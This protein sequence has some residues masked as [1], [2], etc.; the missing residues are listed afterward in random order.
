MSRA[1]F[2]GQNRS[3][4]TPHPCR[5]EPGSEI[6]GHPFLPLRWEI[7]HTH[8]HTRTHT[9]AHT[10][11]RTHT[12]THAHTHTHTHT[13]THAHTHTRTHTHT[14]AHTHTHVREEC[15][16]TSDRKKETTSCQCCNISHPWWIYK[17][18]LHWNQN[19]T[20]MMEN[21][22]LYVYTIR[23]YR[24][25]FTWLMG[26]RIKLSPAFSV[27]LMTKMAP[28]YLLTSIPLRF[29]ASSWRRRGMGHEMIIKFT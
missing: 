24:D 27:L 2:E 14:H 16:Q 21:H 20:N 7:G 18:F 11:T 22:T 8:T 15:A 28:R 23:Y 9:H 4:M 26:M 12:H 29:Q 19:T 17:T 25:V 3:A 13:H 5:S 6:Q 1:F 10:H